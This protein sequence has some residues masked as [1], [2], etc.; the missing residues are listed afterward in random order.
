M[1]RR[2][3]DD[4]DTP[5]GAWLRTKHQERIG[6]HR[7]SA[8]NGDYFWHD[9]RDSWFIFMEEKRYRGKQTKSQRD[10]HGIVT[11]LL[12]KA[13]GAVVETM[14][15]PRPVEFRGYYLIVFDK[16]SPEDGEFTINGMK[17]NEVEL[18]HL[19]ETG[20]MPESAR[21]QQNGIALEIEARQ[22]KD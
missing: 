12:E 15:G 13:S 2:R 21:C 14:R 5:F 8:H 22:S 10:T 3:W 9:Y 4:G 19:L 16:T 1:T 17:A 20:H 18:L 6:S 7:F 11:Q